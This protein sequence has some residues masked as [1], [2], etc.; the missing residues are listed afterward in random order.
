[1]SNH[2][3]ATPGA[4]EGRHS[5]T[6]PSRRARARHYRHYAAEIRAIA[7]AKPAGTIRDQLICLARQ[8]ELLARM[9]EQ[10]REAAAAP[11]RR[12]RLPKRERTAAGAM[13]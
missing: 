8:Y 9:V 3:D 7:E 12:R 2:T 1:M 11:A 13:P 5:E 10:S 6:L 4:G